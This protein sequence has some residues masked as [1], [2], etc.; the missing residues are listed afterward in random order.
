MLSMHQLLRFFALSLHFV[1]FLHAQNLLH[2]VVQTKG[3]RIGLELKWY[4]PS[5]TNN[6]DEVNVYRAE[7]TNPEQWTKINAYPIKNYYLP[8]QG[9]L[10]AR[11]EAFFKRV[12]PTIGN[13]NELRTAMA[14]VGQK[15]VK[16]EG[17]NLLMVLTNS[18]RSKELCEMMGIW[19][20]DSNVVEGKFYQYKV[21]GTS[22][23]KSTLIAKS[24]DWIQMVENDLTVN[25]SLEIDRKR[26]KV[27]F[28]LA[29]E[30]DKFWG[31]NL[32]ANE[33]E[34]WEKVN[35]K[36][37][38]LDQA[39]QDKLQLL[40][41]IDTLKEGKKYQFQYTGIDYFGN[42]SKPS[43]TILFEMKDITPPRS[44]EKFVLEKMS[45]G[46]VFFTWKNVDSLDVE[47]MYL[48][49]RK[50]KE[51]YQNITPNGINPRN[52][53]F[54]DSSKLQ[55]GEYFYKLSV[56]DRAGN[57]AETNEIMVDVPDFT[58][59][60]APKL[61]KILADTGKILLE[62]KLPLEKDLL[63]V[64]IYRGVIGPK[65]TIFSLI[66][67]EP[68]LNTKFS[69]S[70]AKNSKALFA[71]KVRAVDSSFNMSVASNVLAAK[72]PDHTAPH[73]PKLKSVNQKFSNVEIFWF[74]IS[75]D[76]L[77]SFVL[78][79]IEIDSENKTKER[80]IIV[81]KDSL[82]FSDK[83]I[84]PYFTYRYSISAK[85]DKNNQSEFSAHWQ[86]KILPWQ[87]KG[88][89]GKVS[90]KSRKKSLLLSW[91]EQSNAVSY[92]LYFRGLNESEFVLG[93]SGLDKT[94][95]QMNKNNKQVEVR[96]GANFKNGK[97]IFSPTQKL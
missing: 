43:K 76:D 84:K 3:K 69:D 11:T 31:Y 78:K 97:T 48:W 82:R 12:N 70:L 6:F 41:S 96:I 29:L 8:Q 24:N 56:F 36:P 63:G 88:W 46:K 68:F 54:V 71:Y 58:P 61:T 30:K 13:D 80:I 95:A 53:S 75:D 15:G 64:R 94:K 25:N 47:K 39:K 26:K 4:S 87:E 73:V 66:N 74:G 60:S 67:T 23:D 19:M 16:V 50:P 79:K 91:D 44:P 72:L 17:V 10:D 89:S 28:L 32:Y 21:L 65:D 5:V 1:G 18:F 90:I 92:D 93:P 57:S 27:D 85:D 35:N 38:M 81:P 59:P 34:Q 40:L 62:W 49:R 86:V 9:V 83:D 33:K 20:L 42:E 7:K 37:I 52:S 14:I 22:K 2:K 45:N 55:K 51:N 77:K